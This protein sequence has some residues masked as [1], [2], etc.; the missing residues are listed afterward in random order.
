MNNRR[1]YKEG[2]QIK[3][4]TGL[5]VKSHLTFGSL[6]QPTDHAPKNVNGHHKS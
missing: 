5:K 4:N 2:P 1:E 6:F 3:I